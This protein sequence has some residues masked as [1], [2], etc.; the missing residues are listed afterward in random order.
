MEHIHTD[1]TSPRT[2]RITHLWLW[3]HQVSHRR[4]LLLEPGPEVWS[5][6]EPAVQGLDGGSRSPTCQPCL[7]QWGHSTRGS[8]VGQEGARTPAAYLHAAAAAAPLRIAL[9]NPFHNCVLLFL[10]K[11]MNF[12]NTR[13]PITFHHK[14]YTHRKTDRRTGRHTDRQTDRQTGATQG[15]SYPHIGEPLR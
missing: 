8:Y 1:T 9:V 12:G 5:S 4:L 7:Q 3:L 13:V 11:W 14:T 15:L 6:Q 10:M 2:P